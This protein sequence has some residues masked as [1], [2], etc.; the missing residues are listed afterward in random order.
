MKI[1]TIKKNQ[2]VRVSKDIN[3]S[4]QSET[5]WEM[6]FSDDE[7]VGTNNEDYIFQFS[8]DEILFVKKQLV[9]VE[10]WKN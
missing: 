10:I 5:E 2:Q 6:K 9:T 1:Y 4:Y 7:L 3:T 8:S